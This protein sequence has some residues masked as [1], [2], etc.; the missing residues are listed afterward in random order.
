MLMKDAATSRQPSSLSSQSCGESITRGGRGMCNKIR[1]NGDF[2]VR[3]VRKI[4]NKGFGLKLMR[5]DTE[6][7]DTG[8]SFFKGAQFASDADGWITW[9]AKGFGEGGFSFFRSLTMLAKWLEMWKG[10]GPGRVR[11]RIIEY[12]EGLQERKTDDFDSAKVTYAL[13]K[14]FRFVS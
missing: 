2:G 6:G 3:H 4:P 13:A 8:R 12:R 7:S 9:N 14:K 11:I 1:K 5:S 10:P